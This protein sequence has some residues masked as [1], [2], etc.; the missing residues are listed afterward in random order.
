MPRAA[1]AIKLETR[2]ARAKLPARRA[3]YFLTVA[4]GL[5]PGYYRGRGSGSGTWIARRYLGNGEYETG[6]IG[7]ADHTTSADNLA[8]LGHF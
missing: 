5:R 3:P 6:A 2:N 1:R 8:V 4:K 7:S